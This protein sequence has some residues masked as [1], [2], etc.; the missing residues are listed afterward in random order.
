[1]QIAFPNEVGGP[2]RRAPAVPELVARLQAQG[3][4]C[5]VQAGLGGPSGFAD[6]RYEE[7]GAQVV[8]DR[9]T[10][11]SQA[12]IVLRIHPPNDEETTWLRNGCIHVSLLDPFQ[13]RSRLDRLAA[14]GVTA[15][16][17]QM[18]PRITRAQRMDVL[19]SQG[20]L[21]GYVAV[22]LAANHLNRIFPLMMTAAGTLQPARVLV[23][24]AGVA[25]LQAIA[26]AHRLGARVQAFDTRPVVEQEVRSLGARFIKVDLGETGQTRQ[27]YARALTPD[28]LRR[29][30]E[31]LQ[32]V[33]RESDVI[34]TAAQVFGRRAPLILTRSMIE[35]LAP[36]TVVVDLAVENGGNV[37]G[38]VPDQVTRVHGCELIGPSIP[39]ARVPAHASQMFAANLVAWLE[40]WWD[41]KE[42]RLNLDLDD[43]ILKACVLT[44]AGEV[45]FGRDADGVKEAAS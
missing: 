15:V 2:E 44:H 31:A 19:S 22:L 33:C 29:Q 1:M 14:R 6:A 25:G 5:L 32:K 35:E 10:L 3:L 7:A 12:E 13:D 23:I 20:S 24:G 8:P 45:R 18:I 16:S 43:E 36:G 30:Q 40:A 39:P 4:T 37:E 11:F 38:I 28:Q 27:G 26:T 21:A 34:I 17:L 9:Q 41:K 42:G